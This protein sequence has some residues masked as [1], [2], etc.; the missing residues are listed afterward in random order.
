MISATQ[1]FPALPPHLTQL[2][3]DLLFKTKPQNIRQV[4]PFL[5][6]ILLF[7]LMLI[8]CYLDRPEPGSTPNRPFNFLPLLYHLVPALNNLTISL[9]FIHKEPIKK[10][11][12]NK[13]SFRLNPIH[14]NRHLKYSI[15]I[16]YF[17]T[18]FCHMF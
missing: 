10:V 2:R 13:T 4:H 17:C 5:H 11:N 15:F 1:N 14:H 12:K 16:L 3:L 18:T 7:G 9:I 6:F 8:G